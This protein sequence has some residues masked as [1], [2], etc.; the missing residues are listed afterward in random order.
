VLAPAVLITTAP[1]PAT[2][3][4]ASA[5]GVEIVE[6]PLLSDA[7]NRAVARLIN[8]AQARP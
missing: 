1:S 3:A 4:R 5:D 6:K 7:L 2:R 8:A